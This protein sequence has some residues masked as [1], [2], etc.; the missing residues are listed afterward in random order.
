MYEELYGQSNKDIVRDL[1]RRFK[2]YRLRYGKSQKEVAD[3]TGL[4]IFTVSAFES[5]KGTGITVV[6]LLKLLR[7]IEQLDQIEGILPPLPE[8]PRLLFEAQQK[9]L[10]QAG[11]HGK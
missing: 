3:H 1:G 8:S 2:E 10:K 6:N 9:R 11:R 7:S 5:G 4:S